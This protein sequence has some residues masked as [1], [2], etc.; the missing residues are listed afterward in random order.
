[1]F[2]HPCP[3]SQ[4]F[5]FAAD[6]NSDFDIS[7]DTESSSDTDFDSYD[8]TGFTCM[9]CLST[10]F[11]PCPR[12]SR[13]A[14]VLNHVSSNGSVS[15]DVHIQSIPELESLSDS[16]FSSDQSRH[17]QSEE[18]CSKTRRDLVEVMTEDRARRLK[19]WT[20]YE[21]EME[22]E[23]R[24]FRQEEMLRGIRDIVDEGPTRTLAP[25]ASNFLMTVDP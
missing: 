16:S 14:I 3:R 23:R 5:G 8:E 7:S 13:N 17:S 4:P 12:A 6:R 9:H 21:Q 2:D 15:S 11:G 20:S 25:G 1:M 18:R 10:H 22:T 19:D 24:Q